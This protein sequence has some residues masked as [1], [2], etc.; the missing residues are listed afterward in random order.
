MALTHTG[1]NRK[2]LGTKQFGTKYAMTNVRFIA[3]ASYTGSV[4]QH[5]PDV[6]QQGSLFEKSKVDVQLRI[7][8]SNT[9]STISHLAAVN[10]QDAAQFGVPH[11]I[12]I[13]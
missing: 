2:S 7:A 11:A 4:T 10:K 6:V 5:H 3:V 9:Q 8:A 1:M 13:N 12:L